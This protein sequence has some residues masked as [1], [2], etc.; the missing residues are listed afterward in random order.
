MGIFNRFRKKGTLTQ[1]TATGQS[2]VQRKQGQKP[3][4]KELAKRNSA[5][6]KPIS[7]EMQNA[8]I[9]AVNLARLP[10]FVAVCRQFGIS[11][12]KKGF[13]DFYK[14]VKDNKMLWNA[15]AKAEEHSEKRF[16]RTSFYGKL[17]IKC[18]GNPENLTVALMA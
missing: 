16:S 17:F 1:R 18:R 12:P 6:K 9:M 8:E 15:E 14:E 5:E 13:L 11:N 7:E 2:K 4:E 3:V 10:N